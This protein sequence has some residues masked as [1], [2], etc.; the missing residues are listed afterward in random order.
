MMF[1]AMVNLVTT[2]VCAAQ[3]AAAIDKGERSVSSRGEAERQGAAMRVLLAV[4]GLVVLMVVS[5]FMRRAR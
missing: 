4:A 2:F 1:L 5:E 3:C